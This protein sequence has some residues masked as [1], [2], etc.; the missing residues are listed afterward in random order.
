MDSIQT[1][2]SGRAPTEPPEIQLVKRYLRETY[3]AKAEVVVTE[4]EIAV[5]VSSAALA[6][7][8]RLRAGD[9]QKAC[10]LTKRLRFKLI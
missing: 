1:L 10:N 5:T 2:L 6:N 7:T 4:R 3:Q 9:I 8:L